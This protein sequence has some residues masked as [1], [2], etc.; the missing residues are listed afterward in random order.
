MAA[1]FPINWKSGGIGWNRMNGVFS[2]YVAFRFGTP[3]G[4]R[5]SIG[6]V[7]RIGPKRKALYRARK[8]PWLLG[9]I[10]LRAY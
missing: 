6:F 9:C 1:A 8:Q 7:L 3:D 10:Q 4:S 5:K 2:L